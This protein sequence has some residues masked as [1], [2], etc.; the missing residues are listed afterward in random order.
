M[1]I[2][3]ANLSEGLARALGMCIIATKTDIMIPNSRPDQRT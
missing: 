1:T 3:L 2:V